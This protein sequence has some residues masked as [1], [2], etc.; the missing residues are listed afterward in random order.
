MDKY[1]IALLYGFVCV[2]G[3][4]LFLAKKKYAENAALMR[5]EADFSQIVLL[6]CTGF[7]GLLVFKVFRTILRDGAVRKVG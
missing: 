3:D 5:R 2:S 6:G 1:S 4:I 7:S